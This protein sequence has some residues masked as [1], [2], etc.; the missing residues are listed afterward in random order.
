MSVSG[1][2]RV[3]AIQSSAPCGASACALRSGGG[4][5]AVHQRHG[6]RDQRNAV[7]NAVV[8]AHQHR[9]AALVVLDQVESATAGGRVQRLHGQLAHALLQRLLLLALRACG[10]LF[11][12]DVVGDV[13][14]PRLPPRWRRRRP[15]PPLA[16]AVVLEQAL[17]TR[18]HRSAYLMPGLSV[19]TPTIIIRLLGESM[20]S[21]A[22]STLV[23]RSPLRPSMPVAARWRSSARPWRPSGHLFRPHRAQRFGSPCASPCLGAF[24]GGGLI[25]ESPCPILGRIVAVNVRYREVTRRQ[26]SKGRRNRPNPNTQE[27][28][29]ADLKAA[30][31][32]RRLPIPRT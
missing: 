6:H 19:Q 8:D 26:P 11:E 10:Q 28:F 16:K 20:R 15:R 17:L 3:S 13:E 31:R 5:A 30:I 12:R 27:H 1:L 23:M 25:R 29:M 22:V 2:I 21:Q 7:G 32:S 18:W 14:S 9:A 4:G 24:V